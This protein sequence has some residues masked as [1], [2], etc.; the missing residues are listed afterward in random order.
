LEAHL[1]QGSEGREKEKDSTLRELV[2][3]SLL[4]IL[5]DSTANA[6]AK[7]S[8]SRTLLEYFSNDRTINGSGKSRGADMTLAELEQSIAEL[9]HK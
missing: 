6:A 3:Q 8:A 2:K 9:E 5:T 4:A 7:A 1:R